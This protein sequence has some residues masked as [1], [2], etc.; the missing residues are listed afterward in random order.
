MSSDV[1]K[2]RHCRE[3]VEFEYVIAQA[4]LQDRKRTNTVVFMSILCSSCKTVLGAIPASDEVP[5]RTQVERE[6]LMRTSAM[7][8]EL[9]DR[10]EH[11]LS[12]TMHRQRELVVA[13]DARLSVFSEQGDRMVSTYT[14]VLE[15]LAQT[16]DRTAQLLDALVSRLNSEG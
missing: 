11:T 5:A 8:N 9:A 10:L 7:I 6:R 12:E 3:S 14:K 16:H 13:L 1:A 15:D 2:C 4:R